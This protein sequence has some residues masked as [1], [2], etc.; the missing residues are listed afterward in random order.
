MSLRAPAPTL[1]TLLMPC[2]LAA[3][4]HA[5][6]ETPLAAITPPAQPQ[7]APWGF[8][9]GGMDTTVRPGDDFDRYANGHWEDVT[10]LPADR[11]RWNSFDELREQSSRQMRGILE[12]LPADA[13]SGS[14]VQKLHDFYQAYLDTAAIDAAGLAPAQPGLDTIAAARTHEEIAALMERA[15]LRLTAPVLFDITPDQKDPDHYAVVIFQSGLG[16]PDRDYYLKE[17]PA[18]QETRARYRAHIERLLALANVSDAAAAA[19]SIVELETQ[20]AAAHWS[21]AQ[22]RERDRTYNPVSREALPQFA[23]GFP[24]PRMLVAA[25]VAGQSRFVVRESDAVQKLG[26]LFRSV[27]LERWRSYLTYHYLVGNADV[28]P[29]AFDAEVFDFYGR[30]LHGQHEQRARWKRGVSAVDEAL[31]E[32]AGALYVQRYF[33]PG[34]KRQV[35]ELIENVRAAYRARIE[36][37]PWMSAA[38]R[39]LA[40]AKLQA[41]RVEIGYPEHWRDYAALA[42]RRG[43]AFGNRARAAAFD[44]QRQVRGLGGPVDKGEWGITPQTVDAYY[45]ATFNEIVFPAAILQPPFFDPAADAAVNYGAIGGVIGHEL[46]HGFDD[47]GSKSDADGILRNW[48]QPQ[49]AQAFHER[50]DR[51]DAQYSAFEALPGLNVNGRLTLGENIGDLGGAA[52]ANQAYH[53][54]LHGANPPLIN[55]FTGDQRFFLG[56][57]QIWRTRQRDE[58]LR[59]RIASDPHS[60]GRFRVNG[61]VR[62]VDPWY[63]A[64]DVRPG[65]KLY[66]PPAERVRIW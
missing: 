62:N 34:S 64:F 35:L 24:W 36:Q 33:P 43:D 19:A 61:V 57:A 50:V 45:Y 8:D 25:G 4:A 14:N 30:V 52:I 47:Q 53:L 66:L 40:L 41:C 54:S 20:I 7:I 31:G 23:P 39:Q 58:D 46:G 42:V 28:L 65:E 27:P 44:W 26:A 10:Q 16:L 29:S 60:P 15:E 56:W 13:P 6:Q 59:A 5:P 49:D 11:A 51:L 32:A 37:L 38:T 55:H 48:W 63:P 18:Y 2:L 9:L 17:E 1:A 12:A 21:S 3:C 22:R